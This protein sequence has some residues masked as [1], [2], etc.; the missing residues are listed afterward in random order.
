MRHYIR[1]IIMQKRLLMGA[2]GTLVFLGACNNNAEVALPTL[3]PTFTPEQVQ[4]VESASA[5][6]QIVATATTEPTRVRP[7]LPPTFTPTDRPTIT[8]TNTPVVASSTPFSS[9]ATPDLACANFLTIFEQSDVEF[10]E[11]TAPRATWT[12]MPNAELYRVSLADNS[13]RILRDD[14]YIAETTF[15]FASELFKAGTS[16]AWAVYP[17]NARGDQMCFQIGL[18]MLP[19]TPLVPPSP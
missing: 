8:P 5:T 7:T 14:I 19:R 9:A 18:E 16:Y 13:G 3:I 12:A 11:G 6:P 4:T 10:D 1:K 15:T 17:I 2:I